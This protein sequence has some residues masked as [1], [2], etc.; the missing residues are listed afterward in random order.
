MLLF[1]LY[2]SVQ[3]LILIQDYW[4]ALELSFFELWLPTW[5]WLFFVFTTGYVKFVV[6]IELERAIRKIAESEI[7]REF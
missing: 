6:H 3:A 4:F 1:G 5:L 7:G 2:A